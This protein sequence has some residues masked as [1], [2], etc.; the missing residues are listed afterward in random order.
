MDTKQIFKLIKVDQI[1][2][3]KDFY[4]SD[5]EKVSV[6]LQKFNQLKIGHLVVVDRSNK[7]IGM[8]SPKY[9]YRKQSPRKI[10][11]NS[12]RY[13]DIIIDKDCYFEKETLNNIALISII[14]KNP[15]SLKKDDNILNTL[16]KMK[17]RSCL[18]VINEFN[19][20]IGMVSNKEIVN[21]LINLCD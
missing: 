13:K 15:P 6:V 7:L 3:T 18:P 14:E 12:T 5:Y 21:F 4:V 9:I 10:P 11:E 16:K 2:K 17:R 20:V 1:M 19:E 8:I